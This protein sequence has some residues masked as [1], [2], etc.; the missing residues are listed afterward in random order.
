MLPDSL[1]LSAAAEQTLLMEEGDRLADDLARRLNTAPEQEERL[2]FIGRTLAVN[3]VRVFIQ[4]VEDVTRK[5]GQPLRAMVTRDELERPELLVV[6][7][8]GEVRERIA[9]DGLLK[10]AFYLNGRLHPAVETHLRTAAEAGNENL[11]TRAL[12]ACLKSRPVLEVSLP[13]LGRYT[14][15]G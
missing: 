10:S 11:A 7:G 13:Y 3:L 1:P 15:R 12:V 8:D 4:T 6:T 14:R 2:M 9:V 5:V